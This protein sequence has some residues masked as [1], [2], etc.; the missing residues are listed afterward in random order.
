MPPANQNDAHRLTSSRAFVIEQ[1]AIAAVHA[2]AF[3]VVDDNPVSIELGHTVWAA[4]VEG[5]A[6]GLG[7]L[8]H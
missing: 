2:I 1:N 6:L 3:A 4:G 5:C 8:L 7:H